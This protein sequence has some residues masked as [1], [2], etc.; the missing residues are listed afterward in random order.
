MENVTHDIITMTMSSGFRDSSGAR[1]R[2]RAYIMKQLIRPRISPR[3]LFPRMI[4]VRLS[5]H[6]IISSKLL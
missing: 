2:P 6:S 5:G 3:V 1:K 4:A